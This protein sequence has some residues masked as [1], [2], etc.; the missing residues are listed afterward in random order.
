[1]RVPEL[2]PRGVKAAAKLVRG[3]EQVIPN[4][5]GPL[6]GSWSLVDSELSFMLHRLILNG[7][8]V[9]QLV[10]AYAETRWKRASAQEFIGHERPASVP[11][12]YWGYS[13][14]ARMAPA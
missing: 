4:N 6:F 9:P 8:P 12:N 10:Q 1:L 13:G 2:S 7:H 14:L 11:D 5:A 3:A